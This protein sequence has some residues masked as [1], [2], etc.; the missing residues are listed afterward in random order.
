MQINTHLGVG[1]IKTGECP[2]MCSGWTHTRTHAWMCWSHLSSY[3][4]IMLARIE[5]S[6]EITW[7]SSVS[8]FSSLKPIL[9]LNGL[10]IIHQ[11]NTTHSVL[12]SIRQ[13]PDVHFQCSPM[14]SIILTIIAYF[15]WCYWSLL[16]FKSVSVL[17]QSFLYSSFHL[18]V[19]LQPSPHT[20]P[21]NDIYRGS[22]TSE[23]QEVK[24]QLAA[25]V[26]FHRR[27]KV[28]VIITLSVHRRQRVI[29]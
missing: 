24:Y 25:H 20:E 7:F 3:T 14:Y 29:E 17:K 21:V 23:S 12:K 9:D 8:V 18:W 22:Y 2:C 19:M 27:L 4:D 10:S 11:Y 26:C 1:C 5:S 6:S 13:G 15:I 16:W 28:A